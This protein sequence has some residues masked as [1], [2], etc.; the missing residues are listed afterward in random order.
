MSMPSSSQILRSSLTRSFLSAQGH[1]ET[2]EWTETRPT[3]A[4]TADVVTWNWAMYNDA[5]CE[6]EHFLSQVASP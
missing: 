5:E 1:E 3:L 6:R 2:C 4:R